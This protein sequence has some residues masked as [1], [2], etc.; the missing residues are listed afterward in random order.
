MLLKHGQHR[1]SF[2]PDYGNKKDQLICATTGYL[3]VIT[4]V[5]NVIHLRQNCSSIH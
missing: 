2:E 4:L 3:E 1:I 5:Q